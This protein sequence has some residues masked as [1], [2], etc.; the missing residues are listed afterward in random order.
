[1]LEA[2]HTFFRFTLTLHFDFLLTLLTVTRSFAF[3][4]T[5]FDSTLQL[6]V[7]PPVAGG[8]PS[9]CLWHRAEHPNAREQHV[10]GESAAC[11][12]LGGGAACSRGAA[13]RGLIQILVVFFIECELEFKGGIGIGCC[14]E[15][16]GRPGNRAYGR[17]KAKAVG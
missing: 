16:E 8:E 15:G 14:G 1:M 3:D 9:L 11:G 5:A 4:Y 2:F 7:C 12:K 6:G 17:A 13:G 10:W